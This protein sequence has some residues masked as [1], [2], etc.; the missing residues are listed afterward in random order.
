MD[1]PFSSCCCWA[2]VVGPILG[3]NS[4]VA[5]WFVSSATYAIEEASSR[6]SG[7]RGVCLGGH[8]SFL[9]SIRMTM[10]MMMM[11]DAYMLTVHVCLGEGGRGGGSKM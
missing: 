6:W 7:S 10:V 1:E 8:K 4:K 9:S 2:C 3:A 11:A 5:S